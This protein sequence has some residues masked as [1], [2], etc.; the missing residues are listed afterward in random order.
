MISRQGKFASVLG[1]TV[2]TTELSLFVTTYRV[3]ANQKVPFAWHHDAGGVSFQYVY[4]TGVDSLCKKMDTYKSSN[5][6][7]YVSWWQ[8]VSFYLAP[9]RL[10]W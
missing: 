7:P 1:C 10:A 6:D 5:F 3:D 8:N 9:K 2:C 4:S